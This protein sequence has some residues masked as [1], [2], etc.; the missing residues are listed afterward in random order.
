MTAP[1]DPVAAFRPLASLILGPADAGLTDPLARLLSAASRGIGQVTRTELG[2]PASGALPE[3]AFATAG[4]LVLLPRNAACWR[5]VRRAIEARCA[6]AR[7]ACGDDRL[8]RDALDA[9][10]PAASEH[11]GR[12]LIF[13]NAQ[14]R[15]AAAALLDAPFG[16]VTGGPGTGKTTTAAVLLALRRRLDPT[17]A[18]AEVLITAPTGKAACRLAGSLAAAATRLRLDEAERAFLRALRPATLH[19][20]LEWGPAPPE[21][22]GPFR[23]H[24]SRPLEARIVLVD[25]ASMVD[26]PLMAALVVAV[27]P[28][29]ALWM[30]GDSDQLDSVEVGGVLAELVARGAAGPVPDGTL[31]RWS[32]RLGCDAAP[33]HAAGLPARPAADPLPGAAIGLA[34]SY[35]A[36]HAPWILELAALSRPGSP[37]RLGD[38][39]QRCRA[40]EAE[41]R[42]RL[43]TTRQAFRARCREAWSAWRDAVAGW[44]AAAPPEAAAL[45]GL[46]GRFQLL[47]LTNAQVDQANRLG[48][49]LLWQPVDAA[50]SA[51]VPHGCPLLVTV[52]SRSLD[53]SNGDVGVALGT[54]PGQ[55]A[56]EVAFP[57]LDRPLPLA[58]LPGHRPAFALT[59][60]K[61]QGSEWGHVAIDLPEDPGELID[62]HLLYTAITR[63]AGA[64]DLCLASR[65]SWESL[66]AAGAAQP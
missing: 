20:A 17:L 2:L 9:I 66:F 15:L 53:L 7:L 37:A 29:A 35:R 11:V 50:S 52:N 26:L 59:I 36:K 21:D 4:E 34:H 28:S 5:I 51:A 60:H 12:R 58:Q 62:R 38:F 65:G 27:A 33:V 49:D 19:R 1:T 16:I 25:E 22:G 61:S 57:S 63:S 47:C 3:H 18:P 23:R 64:I 32:A 6:S 44:S 55:P 41:G 14:Q 56:T 45:N 48:C 8:V 10:L 30:L 39:L 13:D 24:A 43:F 54:G 40:D 46:L 42:V 31:R